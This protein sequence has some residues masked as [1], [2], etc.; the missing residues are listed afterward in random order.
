[1]LIA[2]III[3]VLIAIIVAGNYS[4]KNEIKNRIQ[5]EGGMLKKYEELIEQ[6]KNED[7]KPEVLTVS[8][9]SVTIGTSNIDGSTKFILKQD[10]DSIIVDWKVQSKTFGNHQLSWNFPDQLDQMKMISTIRSHLKTKYLKITSQITGS[11]PEDYQETSDTRPSNFDER[12]YSLELIAEKLNCNINVAKEKYFQQM[13]SLAPTDDD[14]GSTKKHLIIK[15]QIE[16]KQYNLKALNTPALIYYEWTIQYEKLLKKREASMD[17]LK[18][19]S[20]ATKM[21]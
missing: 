9:L 11:V 1:M 6:I 14:I 2:I 20:D 4:H 10:Y 18:R 16:S 15:S 19:L 8:D 5:R 21:K 3:A 13:D 7:S 17:V 12:K